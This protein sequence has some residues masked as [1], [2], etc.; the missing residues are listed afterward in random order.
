MVADYGPDARAAAADRGPEG[1]VEYTRITEAG[2]FGW[3]YCIGNN[4]PFNDYDFA[5]KKSAD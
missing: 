4:T 1:T 3:P 2:N 5:A